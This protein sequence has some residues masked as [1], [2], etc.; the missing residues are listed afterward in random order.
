MRS[1]FT[2]SLSILTTR[3]VM[4]LMNPGAAAVIA[5]RPTEGLPSLI[6]SEPPSAKNAATLG[7]F[8]LHQAAVYRVANSCRLAGSIGF[9]SDVQADNMISDS[10][11]SLEEARISVLVNQIHEF[12]D[13]RNFWHWLIA[14]VECPADPTS[15]STSSL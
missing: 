1:P 10:A 2:P 12:R 14:G 3:S 13:Y 5:V 7:A 9:I 15:C 4:S 6:F 8:W 11:I